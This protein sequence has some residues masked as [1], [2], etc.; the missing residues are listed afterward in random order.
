[1]S[2]HSAEK[3][4][5][6]S[7]FNPGNYSTSTLP[8]DLIYLTVEELRAH[9]VINFRVVEGCFDLLLNGQPLPESGKV[10]DLGIGNGSVVVAQVKS[11]IAFSPPG[12]I[13]GDN[14]LLQQMS[15]VSQLAFSQPAAVIAAG[16]P[17]PT[18]ACHPIDILSSGRSGSG[19]SD[20][21]Q[22]SSPSSPLSPL[23]GSK[24]ISD[25]FYTY[26]ITSEG[27]RALLSALESLP[28]P[29]ETLSQLLPILLP[30]FSTLAVDHHAAKV[31]IGVVG[32]S[33]STQLLNL[34]KAACSSLTTLCDTTSGSEVLVAIVS[35]TAKFDR[36][37]FVDTATG[38]H[39]IPL[40]V[41]KSMQSFCTSVNGRKVL[42]AILF[43]LSQS[44]SEVLFLATKQ[45]LVSYATNQCG[46]ITVQR[47][48][49]G[50][51]LVHKRTLEKEMLSMV[52]HLLTDP[53]GN[54][55][56]QHAVIDNVE[57]SIAIAEYVSGQLLELAVNKFSSN[58]VEKCI[59]TGPDEVRENI[60]TEICNPNTLSH[61]M[62]DAF[63]NYVVQS[64]VDNAPS[65]LVDHLRES[66]TPF[67]GTSPY[68]YRIETKL[69]RRV[70]KGSKQQKKHL[71]N[72]TTASSSDRSPLQLIQPQ[73]L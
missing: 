15:F 43:Q 10:I 37:I 57:F 32:L 40:S 71:Q 34:T 72:N 13:L 3:P 25:E 70:K 59:Q 68:G 6:I 14:Q 73:Q 35:A 50:A 54:Y 20:V 2:E 29:S 33:D 56:L 44:D 38:V 8:C 23:S 18:V 19:G 61:L 27:S 28:D 64:A 46:C 11:P 60:I 4:H 1:M 65:G 52:S 66:I 22:I 5:L 39:M 42:Q 31:V 47:M 21:S 58:V 41:S 12:N 17:P 36:S 24:L 16:P 26:V 63:G 30:R 9:A 67:L 69:Q 49:D 53:Y 55:V 45:N 7:L 48:Y 62:Q 51:S